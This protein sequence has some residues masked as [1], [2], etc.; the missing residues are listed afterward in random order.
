MTEA[1]LKDRGEESLHQQEIMSDPP[2]NYSHPPPDIMPKGLAINGK[3]CCIN[4][5]IIKLKISIM[6]SQT[7]LQKKN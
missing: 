6:G 3:N 7:L 5:K 4:D 1:S 2:Q